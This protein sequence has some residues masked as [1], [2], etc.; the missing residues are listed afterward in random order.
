MP[1]EPPPKGFFW[2]KDT[3]PHLGNESGRGWALAREA[4]RSLFKQ[5]GGR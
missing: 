5:M 1:S 4:D 3:T 2:V